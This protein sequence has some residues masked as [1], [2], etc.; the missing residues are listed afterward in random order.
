ML[1]DIYMIQSKCKSLD[2]DWANWVFLKAL[3]LAF[4]ACPGSLSPH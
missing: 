3:A 2:A 4:A 1:I